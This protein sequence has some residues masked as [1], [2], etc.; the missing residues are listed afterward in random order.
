VPRGMTT[1]SWVKRTASSKRRV[2]VN[3]DEFEIEAVTLLASRA[4][5]HP[6]ELIRSWIR[7]KAKKLPIYNNELKEIE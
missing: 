5:K 7:T 6:A 2:I 4:G 3:M 1:D